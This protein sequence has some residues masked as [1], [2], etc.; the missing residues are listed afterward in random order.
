M[1]ALTYDVAQ[2]ETILCFTLRNEQG[3][4]DGVI[5]APLTDLHFIALK[6][7]TVENETGMDYKVEFRKMLNEAF[8][9]NAT[10]P[11]AYRILNIIFDVFSREK[12]SSNG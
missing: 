10:A 3:E 6:A 2:E 9:V 4:I 7:Q 5:E 1:T 11:A 8:R 12:K